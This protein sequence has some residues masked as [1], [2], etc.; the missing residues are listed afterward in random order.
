MK[1]IRVSIAI[2][3]AI[4]AS[5]PFSFAADTYAKSMSPGKSNLISMDFQDANLK[6]VLK[7]FSQQSGLN[8]IASQNIQE[9]TVTV[10]FENVK[11]EEALSY[12]MNANNLVYEQ[13]P[14]T[15]IFIVKETG[16]P[17]VET[18]TKIYELKYAQ[19]NAPTA[20]AADAGIE[21]I[22]KGVLS[23]NGKII[24]DKRS[25]SLIITDVPS[26][27]PIVENL[28]SKLDVRTSQVMIR[29]EILETSTALVESL[30]VNWS[31]EFGTFTGPATRTIWPMNNSL[32]RNNSSGEGI[33]S[34]GSVSLSS[35][36]AT[37]TALLNNSDTKILARPQILTMNNETAEI[38]INS[39]DAIQ[40]KDTITDTTTGPRQ[41]SEFERAQVDERP[42]ITLT[43]TP[44]ISKSD[45]ITMV[46]QPKL[47][48]KTL[49]DLST[50][51]NKL[52]DLSFRTAK[53]TV[54]VKDGET[55]VIG[56]LIKSQHDRGLKKVPFLGDIPVLGAAFRYKSKDNT[57]RELIIFITPNIIKDIS[58]AIGNVSEREQEKPKAIREKE[59]NTVLDLF[60][61]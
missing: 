24:A 39:N 34:A 16:K 28:L 59:I 55:V 27:F 36:T 35:T 19:M 18:V 37:L 11:V 9:R 4:F 47:I 12:I 56:G 6:T 22:V 60:G 23:E 61:G 46:I 10:Y 14:G 42:G 33:S 57:D 38:N 49:S 30:G 41:T 7:V 13:E 58:Y 51:D 21:T 50:T 8:F 31:G 25:N 3:F 17:K 29:V 40:R 15:S 2:V 54:M 44:T 43:V 5:A 48:S 20:S 1:T 52:F 26:Q 53:T 32:G 45:F